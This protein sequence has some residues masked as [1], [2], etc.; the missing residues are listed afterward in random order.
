[1]L[2]RVTSQ[3]RSDHS[4]RKYHP[5]KNPDDSEAEKKFKE[6]QEA[7][8]HFPTKKKEGSMTPLAIADQVHPHSDQAVFKE[9]TLVL[10]IYSVVDLM[11]FST[12]SSVH[13]EDG[14]GPRATISCIVTQYHS[15][16]QWMAQRMR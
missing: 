10:M 15:K 8:A 1:M 16:S 9:L 6:V 2:P 3:R 13:P 7:F 12:S 11:V 14:G 5:D 4:A